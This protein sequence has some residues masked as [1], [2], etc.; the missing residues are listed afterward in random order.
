MM[1]QLFT[2]R[3]SMICPSAHLPIDAWVVSSFRP[4]GRSWCEYLCTSLCS[5]TFLF[6]LGK[7]LGM[8]FLGFMINRYLLL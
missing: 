2:D 5:D 6:L 3:G 8:D 1:M 4:D 7:H